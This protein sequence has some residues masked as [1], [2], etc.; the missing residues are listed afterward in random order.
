MIINYYY[1]YICIFIE[2]YEPIIFEV[3]IDDLTKY[4][5]NDLCGAVLDVNHVV[6]KSSNDTS[7]AP[8]LYPQSLAK[9]LSLNKRPNFKQNDFIM[10]L[11]N[12]KSMGD[13]Y[14]FYL[15][16]G[17]ARTI[18]HE[19]IHG[20]GHKS[21]MSIE[22]LRK[23]D[24]NK[25]IEEIEKSYENDENGENGEN[26]ENY[27]KF[28]LY[29]SNEDVENIK[30]LPNSIND[31]N[32]D[33]I[34]NAKNEK[35]IELS[36]FN[37]DVYGFYPLSVYDKY[38][39]DINSKKPI[40]E[41]LTHLYED[42]NNCYSNIPFKFSEY[43]NKT[44]ECFNQLDADTKNTLS[45]LPQKYILKGNSIGILTVDNTVVPLQTFDG[46]YI[47]GSSVHHTNSE[48]FNE[49]IKNSTI[50][51]AYL[52]NM[53]ITED[54]VEY[55]LDENFIMYFQDFENLPRDVL[56]RTV[57]K[58]NKH[59]LIGPGIVSILKTLGWTEKGEQPS[60]DTYYLVEDIEIPEQNNFKEYVLKIYDILS[61][62]QKDETQPTEDVTDEIE[63]TD[64]ESE[65]VTLDV[66]FDD[67]STLS[68]ESDSDTEEN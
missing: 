3:F 6:L 10:I 45:T 26:G 21:I 40:F 36:T 23:F 28:I 19:I 47:D 56:L 63:N 66:V 65:E 54:N 24:L 57:A 12:M 60:N 7:S 46:F 14:E 8:Y 39:V 25:S 15:K 2:I 49:I 62:N 34:K 58:N 30:I 32:S 44:R 33:V 1:T 52:N 9:Q 67:E 37:A 20:L 41:K 11:N 59:G 13:Y 29:L 27:D 50:H 5:M 48:I 51:D 17:Y 68:S 53:L 43:Y 42:L 61:N 64:N 55:Y 31:F 22:D 18:I 35:E 16:Q 4:E 38:I